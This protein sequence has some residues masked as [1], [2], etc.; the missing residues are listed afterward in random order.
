[1]D[2]LAAALCQE[3]NRWF[4][5]VAFNGTTLA[6]SNKSDFARR[7]GRAAGDVD[8]QIARVLDALRESGKL[9]NTV[10]IVTAGHGVPLGDETKSMS[11]SR[12]TC[13]F[14]W[15]STGRAPRRSASL[16]LPSIKM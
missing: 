16:C 5:W 2:K 11:W 13:R 6:N 3:D 7:Y 15:S 4:S 8:A 14:R 12:L 10:V 9:D 1:M